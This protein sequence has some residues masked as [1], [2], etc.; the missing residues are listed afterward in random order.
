MFECLFL[1]ISLCKNTRFQ[2]YLYIIIFLPKFF[3]GLNT[4][5]FVYTLIEGRSILIC[6]LNKN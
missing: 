1:G 6:Y 5:Y 2:L 4:V 3:K